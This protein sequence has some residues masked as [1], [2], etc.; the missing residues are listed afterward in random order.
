M[1][2]KFVGDKI[3]RC[4]CKGKPKMVA[5]FL[6]DTGRQYYVCARSTNGCKAFQ[7]SPT[8]STYVSKVANYAEDIYASNLMEEY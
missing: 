1:E 6:R 4:E 5:Y 8:E 3:P 7:L 2:Q